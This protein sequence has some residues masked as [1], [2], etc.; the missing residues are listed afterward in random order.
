[1]DA[2]NKV[3][4]IYRNLIQEHNNL[5]GKLNNTKGNSDMIAYL[6]Q[7]VDKNILQLEWFRKAFSTNGEKVDKIEK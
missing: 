7:E 6:Q 4:R 3:H 2:I 5:V 1:M